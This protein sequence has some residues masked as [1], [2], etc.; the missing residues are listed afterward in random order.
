MKKK[1]LILLLCVVKLHAAAQQPVEPAFEN[2]PVLYGDSIVFPLTLVDAFPFISASVNGLKGKF[3]FDTGTRSAIV[4]N[5]NAVKLSHMKEI[6]KGQVGSG[7][8]YILHSIDTISE[9][10]FSN[11]LAY[12]NLLNIESANFDFLQKNITPDCI[13]YIGYNFFV[14]YIFKLDYLKRKV[15]FYKNTVQ[16]Q[17]SKD[18][19]NG[20]KVLAVLNFEIRN[21]P[22][23]PM[24]HLK[25]GNTEVL[26]SFDTGQ[27][28]LLQLEDQAQKD[29][30]AN[31]LL[32]SAGLDGYDTQLINVNDVEINGIFK[33]NLKGIYPYTLEKTKP[34]RKAL[35]ITEA[36]YMSLGYRFL[37]EYKTVWDYEAKKIYI[38]ER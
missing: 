29:L 28:G 8:S 2:T 15:T 30:T 9:V 31:A 14:G 26:G 16:R 27:Y 37:D 18:F 5:E 38:L 10:K 24:V 17:S 13:G 7:Q 36:S 20:E 1:L 12:R 11:G 33:V 35:Q 3:M 22:N 6:R 23:H 34:F 25:I 32:V 4:I 21:L 19:L